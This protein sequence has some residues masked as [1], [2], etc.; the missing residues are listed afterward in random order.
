[1]SIAY[2]N[3]EVSPRPEVGGKA[4]GLEALEAAGLRVPAWTVI[5]A[6]VLLDQLPTTEDA[7][8]LRAA[9]CEARV[10]TTVLHKLEAFFGT[11]ARA[12]TYAVRSSAVG[13]DGEAHSYA[14]QFESYLHV[15][16]MALADRVAE[17]WRSVLAERVRHYRER[18]A[19]AAHYGVGV[20]VQRMVPADVAGV[21]FGAD[22]VT[23][24]RRT[25]VISAVFGLGEGLVN[26]D[27][28]ADTYRVTGDRITSDIA[29]KTHGYIGKYAGGGTQR[30]AI[31]K[32][33]QTRAALGEAQLRELVSALDILE[34]ALGTPQD[35]EFAYHNTQVYFL[36]TRPVTTLASNAA[37]EYTLWDNSNI[38]ESYPGITTPLTFSFIQ[39]MYERVYRQFV[40]IMGVSERRINA[41]APVF[42]QT[43]GLVRGRV[44]YN[45]LHWYKMLALMP[46]YSLNAE[47]M[48][49]MMGVKERFELDASFRTGK[50]RAGLRTGWMLAKMIG[51][52]VGLPRSRRKFQRDLNAIM[53]EYTALRFENMTAP[54]IVDAYQNF[55]TRLLLRWKAPL[56]NDFF[57]MIW[58]GTLRKLCARHCPDHPNLHNDL[59]CGSQDI[60]SV[61]PVRRALALAQQISADPAA[62]TLFET[63]DATVIWTTLKDGAYPAILAA[64]QAYLHDFG[65][66]CVGELK[67]ETISYGQD[68]VRFVR[69]VQ[70]YVTRGV[71]RRTDDG[72]LSE[73][74]RRD[75]EVVVRKALRGKPL[76]RSWFKLVLRQTRDLVSHRENLRY[77]RTRGFGMVRRM[78]TALGE[79]LHADGRLPTPRDVFYL[80][81]DEIKSLTD[82]QVLPTAAELAD[83]KAAFATYRE[84]IPP[85]SRFF[86]Y[87]TAFTDDRIYASDK[88]EPAATDLQGTG[89]C[90][91]VVQGRVRVVTDPTTIDSLDGDILVTTSTDPG[92]VTL[93]PTASAIV[94][95]RGSLLSHSAIVAREMGIPCVVAVDGLLRSLR[96]GDRITL[97]GSSGVVQKMTD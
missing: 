50:A 51:L 93:F 11:G 34:Q 63:A 73:T 53:A 25:K 91:G 71:H 35:V 81:L 65:E 80:E 31:A 70:G 24:K 20:I 85:R 89:C 78:F 19:L 28:N 88:L 16:F 60:I 26:G 14:G 57:A 15:P 83:R 92:W 55:E 4:R 66:R 49:Q 79:R 44:Y 9:V 12:A 2:K 41:H 74:L 58:F 10:P 82:S 32:E 59:L 87:G 56:V 94:V 86:T 33:R 29:R 72:R 52:Q 18:R 8:V 61:A 43:L 54:Q 46:G 13:E 95:E 5:P 64:F 30:L 7:A 67:L 96:T 38:V 90:P 40:G 17:V 23:G 42:A 45:L 27:L 39:R 37:G 77:E 68:P 6:N 48:E 62:K 22:P 97:D 69:V 76:A 84:Q 21:A 47:F 1:M 36:Q 75:A 3:I